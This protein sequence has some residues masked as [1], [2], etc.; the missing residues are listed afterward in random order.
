MQ[1]EI[2]SLKC[3]NSEYIAQLEEENKA[4]L[5][6]ILKNAKSIS[7]SP[8]YTAKSVD[9]KEYRS[10]SPFRP[11][12]TT[13]QPSFH[14][15]TLKQLKETIEELY[16]AKG[17]FDAKCNEN[18]QPRET[19]ENFIQLYLTQKYGLK[20]LYNQWISLINQ[21]VERFSSDIDVMIFQK[22]R[23]F[24]I[25]EE[26]LN[27]VKQVKEK[28]SENI[29]NFIRSKN[30]YMNERTIKSMQ[31]EVIETEIDE[32]LL[33]FL[34]SCMPG[35]DKAIYE[36]LQEIGASS[37]LAK[38]TKS[39]MFKDFLYAVLEVYI[40]DHE[41]RIGTMRNSFQLR[42][43]ENK[44]T[45][46]LEHFKEIHSELE[47]SKDCL[48]SIQALDPHNSGKITFSDFIIFCLSEK[49]SKDDSFISVKNKSL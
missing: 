41:N 1:E 46:S 24:S 10:Y 12:P 36:K 2:E 5:E 40:K 8:E 30:Q 6:K 18:M 42:D 34:V 4:Y 43:Y 37:K 49:P 31:D 14:S 17:K 9:A 20:S 32:M 28:I 35:K 26:F 25:N 47:L 23:S 16:Q 19:F 44:G 29:R 15:L 21:G 11:R 38:K 13:P 39:V 48:K 27:G 7:Y 45:I 22:I 3:Q 33:G